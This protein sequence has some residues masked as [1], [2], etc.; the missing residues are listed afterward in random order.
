MYILLTHYIFLCV[1][2]NET[3]SLSSHVSGTKR[4]PKKQWVKL[5]LFSTA[6]EDKC[7]GKFETKFILT[8]VHQFITMFVIVLAISG[9]NFNCKKLFS[10]FDLS[11]MFTQFHFAYYLLFY[12]SRLPAAK[13]SSVWLQ[14]K[15]KMLLS[16]PFCCL[17]FFRLSF[18]SLAKVFVFECFSLFILCSISPQKI[19]FYFTVKAT[20][21][22]ICAAV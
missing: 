17:Q 16:V 11:E 15:L 1:T 2:N 20:L 9:S 13:E 21:T 22:R 8:P 14:N 6:R 7:D 5:K 18:S 3:Q 12:S 4:R 10:F 19:T